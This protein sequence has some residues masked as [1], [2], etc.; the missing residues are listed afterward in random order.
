MGTLIAIL[1]QNA[2]PIFA[3]V[4][5]LTVEVTPE[6]VA[7]KITPRTKAVIAGAP[8]GP[9][10]GQPGAL[11]AWRIAAESPWWRT[12][13]RATSAGRGGRYAGTFGD[14]G[15]WSLNESKHIGAGDGGIMLTNR[16]GLARRADLFADKCYDREGRGVQPFFAPFNYRLNTLVAGGLPGAAQESPTRLLHSEPAGPLP[17]SLRWRGLTASRR[18]PS[19]RATTPRTGTTSSTSRRRKFHCTNTEFAAAM[20]AEGIGV[21][22]FQSNVMDWPI[23]RDHLLSPHA[24][25]D[26]CP[27]YK[28]GRPDYD[29]AHY[30]GAMEVKRR[31]IQLWMNDFFTVREMRDLVRAAAK[32][33]AH[34]RRRAK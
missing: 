13:R 32:V 5:P 4:D 29:V 34:Y 24:C 26:A 28:G 31:T 6:T 20:R 7:R 16:Q 19:A 14:I 15:C 12:W 27:L 33:A 3:D 8:G 9:P 18:A 11:S 10:G 2:V 1:A 25:A 17:G 22:A 21:G 30:P 23:F